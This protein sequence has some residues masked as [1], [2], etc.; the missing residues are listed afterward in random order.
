VLSPEKLAETFSN[1]D[2]FDKWCINEEVEER[3][4]MLCYVISRGNA[5]RSAEIAEEIGLKEG[6]RIRKKRGDNI[7]HICAEYGKTDC[8]KKF[9]ELGHKMDRKNEADE[10]PLHVACREG[11]IAIVKTYIRAK[12]LSQLKIS[13]DAQM[14]DGWTPFMYA[15]VNGYQ[16]IVDLLG[17]PRYNER[18]KIMEA[19][20]SNVN[21]CDSLKRNSLH[22]VIK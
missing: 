12:L 17:T 5:E 16:T 9:V 7:L 11:C 21:W 2:R 18:V 1:K 19:P 14:I 22:W 20:F 13:L 6:D 4:E 15:A 3:Y 8:F 10:Y